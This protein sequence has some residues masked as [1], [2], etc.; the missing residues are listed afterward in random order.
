MKAYWQT[1]E[2]NYYEKDAEMQTEDC[3]FPF[4]PHTFVRV[5]YANHSRSQPCGSDVALMLIKDELVSDLHLNVA[6]GWSSNW[7]RMNDS[8]I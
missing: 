8:R 5:H 2:K 7:C 1:I 4:V 6:D 3:H